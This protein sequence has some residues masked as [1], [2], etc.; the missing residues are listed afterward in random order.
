MRPG[1]GGDRP[2]DGAQQGL[3]VGG[4]QQDVGD[5]AGLG[6]GLR[7]GGQVVGGEEDDGGCR[8]CRGGRAELLRELVAVHAGHEHVGEH[9]VG[10]PGVRQAERLAALVRLDDRV[11]AVGQDVA[12]QLTVGSLVIDDEDGAHRKFP[13][14]DA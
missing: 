13:S 3:R 11:P 7:L 12:D 14:R 9:Q 8:R 4:L 5:A 1:G 10:V 2:V 6:D